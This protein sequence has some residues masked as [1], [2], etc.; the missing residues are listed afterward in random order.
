VGRYK[1]L[2]TLFYAMRNYPKVID[3]A[4]R[5][6]K[7]GRDLELEVT[8]GQAYYL[9][10]D[11]KNALKVMNGVLA[12]I[13]SRNQQPKEQTLHL[14]R[15]ACEK[16][17]D[18]SCVTKVYEK[19]V[20]F[21]PKTEYWQN[22]LRALRHGDTND[23]QKIN[24]LRLASAVDVLKDGDDYTEFAQIALDEGLPAE[25]QAALEK[26]FEKKLFKDQR[27]IDLNN[28]LLTKAKSEVATNKAKLVQQDADA[29]A[30]P[31][32][33][34]DVKVGAAYL[35][36]GDPAKAV[37]V[38]KRGITQGKLEQADEAGILLGI[39]YLRSDNKAEAKKAF[40]RV[41]KSKLDPTMARIANLWLLNT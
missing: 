12:T 24:V 30:T 31:A 10:N 23:K 22:L 2:V 20:Q 38:I 13:E 1:T 9:T 28:R 14:I 32:G 39:A 16:V 18:N 7:T 26:A 8:L 41:S 37:E 17:N 4:N 35:S 6:L 40:D 34:D 27:K 19:L 25:A 33:D 21:Y 3:Y 11:N 5:A 29:R 36:Y 15:A